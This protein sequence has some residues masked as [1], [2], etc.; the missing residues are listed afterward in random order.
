MSKTKQLLMSLA[1]M[2]LAT[3][4]VG[5]YAYFGV[6]QKEREAEQAKEREERLFA[7]ASDD[8]VRLTVHG[9]G[10]TTVV[11]KRDGGWRVTSPV[12]APADDAVV[13]ELLRQVD[14]AKRNRVVGEGQDLAPFGL[15]RPSTWIEVRAAD[16][17]EGRLEIGSRS[18]FDQ[19][20]YVSV[21]PGVVL[22]ASG[23]LEDAFAK[24]TFDLRDKRLLTFGRDRLASL[25]LRGD[26]RILLQREEGAWKLAEPIQVGADE[27]E[28]GKVLQALQD[29][30][31]TAF[32][33]RDAPA[34][35]PFFTATLT[36]TEGNPL[37]LRL[38]REDGAVLAQA[39]GGPLAEIDGKDIARID[40][41]VDALRDRRI[42]PFSTHEVARMEVVAGDER[43]TLTKRDGEWR[44]TAPEE[45]A[46]KRWKVQAALSNLA[47]A[48]YDRILPGS[49]A[50][51]HGLVP[52]ARTIS[53]FDEAGA[54]VGAFFLGDEE[55]GFVYLQVEGRDD[56]FRTSAADLGNVPRSVE[57]V[58]EVQEA[59]D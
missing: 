16:G 2:C 50:A 14:F 18:P 55:A 15:D 47:S 21:E 41:D 23:A 27:Q 48:R 49:D 12:D 53:L 8:L 26:E 43:F 39:D 35:D 1:A 42:A 56:V 19:S 31:A 33:S 11:E 38:W 10:E 30:R 57:D 36:L 6:F 34:G 17:A 9:K 7:I 28:V 52:P 58:E 22:T 59:A 24:G 13:R 32:P 46:A 29:L 20:L 4:A 44:I 54:S 37:S 25:E 51:S 3:V 40:R 45:A 5:A